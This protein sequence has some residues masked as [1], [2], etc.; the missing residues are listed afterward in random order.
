M[1]RIPDDELGEIHVEATMNYDA[2][3]QVN[4]PA[5]HFSAPGRADSLTVPIHL[6]SLFPLEL[7]LLL[8]ANG[9][10]LSRRDGDFDGAPFASE[11]P[12][13]LCICRVD[14]AGASTR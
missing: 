12:R 4:R 3:T 11:S 8:S 5:F 6:R 1:A 13:Q 10:R 9:F 14:D 7:P 2:A